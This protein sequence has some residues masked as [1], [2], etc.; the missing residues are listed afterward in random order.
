MSSINYTSSV[1]HLVHSCSVC[2]D[3]VPEKC[4]QIVPFSQT[5]KE[6]FVCNFLGLSSTTEIPKHVISS[7]MHVVVDIVVPR[8]ARAGA[9]V[10][11]GEGEA[12]RQRENGSPL[13]GYRLAVQSNSKNGDVKCKLGEIVICILINGQ[14]F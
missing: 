5:Y 3:L 7:D 13:G 8:M 9:R 11:D 6:P 14:I 4:C 12:G 2:Q 10:R 1:L